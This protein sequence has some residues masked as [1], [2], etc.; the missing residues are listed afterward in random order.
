MEVEKPEDKHS[1]DDEPKVE[2]NESDVS[3]G[4]PN[5]FYLPG[6]AERILEIEEI[7]NLTVKMIKR[8][9]RQYWSNK[10]LPPQERA[11]VQGG[12]EQAF[13]TLSN[14]IIELEQNLKQED[15]EKPEDAFVSR[16]VNLENDYPPQ[17]DAQV[18][19]ANRL[20][21]I[22]YGSMIIHI[23]VR[24]AFDNISPKLLC[25]ILEK[26]A[27]SQ[28][29]KHLMP[30]KNIIKKWMVTSAG[31]QIKIEGYKEFRRHYGGPQGSLWTPSIWN[32]YLTSI[33]RN[34]PLKKMIRLY[35]DNIFI[36][37]AE[38]NI[39]YN[40]ITKVMQITKK[41]LK[42][43]NLDINEDEIFAYWKG[44]KKEYADM[45][46]KIIPLESQQRILGYRFNLTDKG[47]WD[48]QI[49]FW[50][51][52]S[53]RRSLINITFKQRLLAFKSKA[54]GS[55]YYQIQGWYLFG[56]PKDKYNW[57][58]IDQN[59]RQAF[60]NWT[61]LSKISYFD[62]A[63]LGI[64]LRPYLIDKLTT[65]Y[66]HKFNITVRDAMFWQDVGAP[67]RAIIGLMQDKY[68]DINI[69]S[70][71]LAEQYDK[72]GQNFVDQI[73]QE[74]DK[75]EKWLK[76][77]IQQVENEDLYKDSDKK[78]KDPHVSIYNKPRLKLWE[79]IQNYHERFCIR[80]RYNDELHLNYDDKI[81]WQN[82]G[83][84][85][86]CLGKEPNTD[87]CI[88]FCQELKNALTQD[89]TW[90]YIIMKAMEIEDEGIEGDVK[91][92]DF[93]KDHD[94][95]LLDDVVQI[96]DSSLAKELSWRRQQ[97]LYICYKYQ[98]DSEIDKK[99]INFL[100]LKCQMPLVQR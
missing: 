34:S 15:F 98:N 65:A 74:P 21:E 31:E 55:L 69:N 54:L 57:K 32:L 53:P 43:A 94:W 50:L 90:T 19:E 44:E 46:A 68:L 40:Y 37:I 4:D 75:I 14:R 11:Q 23:D 66:C 100:Q 39:N 84:W 10:E 13:Q 42:L 60:I 7:A 36:W 73:S 64:L 27:G 17:L 72:L 30:F 71:K 89:K 22:E 45:I 96:M 33:L 56:D 8:K 28:E 67:Y 2:E 38:K 88:R 29:F 70:K 80:R 6:Q 47:R 3:I 5:D 20:K 9:I 79:S 25:S 99:Y 62:L 81:R 83:F 97:L 76:E 86:L 12:I 1:Q 91:V 16:N 78:Y 24:R 18:E 61:G 52:M 95:E 48:Y 93:L 87:R 92:R 85:H 51:P 82:R 58:R 63:A 49:K 41:L 35:A 59:I 26:M 77:L